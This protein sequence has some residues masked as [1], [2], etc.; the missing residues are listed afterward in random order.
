MV[1]YFHYCLELLNVFA[2]R[3]KFLPSSISS[4]PAF[5][6]FA[7]KTRCQ[8]LYCREWWKVIV[9]EED[10]WNHGRTTPGNEQGSH[11]HLYCSLQTIVVLTVAGK[12]K[13]CVDWHLGVTGGLSVGRNPI[14]KFLT[15]L[16]TWPLQMHS[17]YLH[18]CFIGGKCAFVQQFVGLSCVACHVKKTNMRKILHSIPAWVLVQKVVIRQYR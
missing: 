4:Y 6:M 17:I 14:F 15:T 9:T 16:C 13:L 7:D 10:H 3:Q 8:I 1:N 18:Y 2:R 12:A 5:T 11:C